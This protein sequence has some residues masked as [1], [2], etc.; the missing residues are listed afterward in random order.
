MGSSQVA[1]A[2]RSEKSRVSRVWERRVMTWEG[3][4]TN[5][6][7]VQMCQT[8]RAFG[9]EYRRADYARTPEQ[10]ALWERHAPWSR[11]SM[12]VMASNM[13]EAVM[14][15][16]AFRMPVHDEPCPSFLVFGGQE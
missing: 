13:G 10:R 8:R 7:A 16:V 6:L 2:S 5:S 11:G 9:Y 15:D 1:P 12:V 14:R 3:I 4:N